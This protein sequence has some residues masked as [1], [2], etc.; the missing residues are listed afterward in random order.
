MSMHFI[1]TKHHTWSKRLFWLSRKAGDGSDLCGLSLSAL[2][3]GTFFFP[4]SIFMAAQDADYVKVICVPTVGWGRTA[5]SRQKGMLKWTR[6]PAA[7]PQNRKI[8]TGPWH[9]LQLFT[10]VASDYNSP[11]PVNSYFFIYPS[12]RNQIKRNIPKNST[13]SHLPYCS[14]T[15]WTALTIKS[16]VAPKYIVYNILVPF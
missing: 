15:I 11:G 16:G 12:N 13:G 9:S 10:S 7:D 4:K 8:S 6:L 2:S 1:L 14:S 5:G 3:L